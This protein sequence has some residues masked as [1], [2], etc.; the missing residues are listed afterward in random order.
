MELP[1]FPP[2]PGAVCLAAFLAM[3]AGALAQVPQGRAVKG[4]QVAEQNPATAR[5]SLLTGK[6]ALALTRERFLIKGLRLEVKE[7]GRVVMLIEAPEC[8]Y[9]Y[10]TRSAWSTNVLQVKSGDSRLA[11]SGE[12]FE[13][14]ETNAVLTISNKVEASIRRDLVQAPKS[15]MTPEPAR[16]APAGESSQTLQVRSRQF[17]YDANGR[18]VLFSGGTQVTDPSLDLTCDRLTVDLP[19]KEGAVERILAEGQVVILGRDDGLRAQSDAATYVQAEDSLELTGHASWSMGQRSGRAPVIRLARQQRLLKVPRDSFLRLPIGNDL[20]GFLTGTNATKRA[21]G[22]EGPSSDFIEIQSDSLEMADSRA[23]FL[24]NVEARRM[25][26][27]IP[28]GSLAAGQ[29]IAFIAASNRLDRIEAKERVR[30]R[31]G[32]RQAA[33][34]AATYTADGLMVL[35]ENPSWDFDQ[36]QGRAQ[37][38]RFDTQSGKLSAG[39]RAEVVLAIPAGD[40]PGLFS[41][42][43]TLQPTH[44]GA[45]PREIRI[46]SAQLD[47]AGSEA[48]FTGGVVAEEVS[49]A[50][51]MGTLTATSLAVSLHPQQNTLQRIVAREKVVVLESAT[52][53]GQAPGRLTCNSI[54]A[55]FE[56]AQAALSTV[57][58]E[59]HV[60]LEQEGAVIRADK[61]V[62]VAG[63]DRVTLTGHPD[64]RSSQGILRGAESV[65][66]DRRV[67]KYRATGPWRLEW[68]PPAKGSRAATPAG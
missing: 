32:K 16:S 35:T 12:G 26:G 2:I 58:A 40:K 53:G 21:G 10:G 38:I 3:A 62:F 15:A 67:R 63:E 39:P 45:G 20:G 22:A 24:G 56:G 54:T 59:E 61:A 13:W 17:S 47:Y 27:E 44:A 30:I 1:G 29:L 19:E 31:E 36:M 6:D 50:S 9:D 51:V 46:R 68:T 23:T 28:T 33:G 37:H 18:R 7:Q 5:Q 57:T 43:S 48:E 34:G 64:V 49:G 14:R 65:V 41:L 66:W 4:F 60:V 42:G 11:L 25:Q 52:P 55:R 8:F